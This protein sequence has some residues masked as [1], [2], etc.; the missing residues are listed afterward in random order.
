MN[1][2]LLEDHDIVGQEHI[3]LKDLECNNFIHFVCAVN[4]LISSWGQPVLSYID[5]DMETTNYK[6]DGLSHVTKLY[7]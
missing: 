5:F 7:G 4:T 1:C 6:S 3:L 2:Q